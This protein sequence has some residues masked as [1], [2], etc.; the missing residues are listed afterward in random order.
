MSGIN[1]PW[2]VV[3]P[4][5]VSLGLL[6]S[7]QDFSLISDRYFPFKYL[8]KKKEKKY[9]FCSFHCLL[10]FLGCVPFVIIV[11]V[12]HKSLSLKSQQT[13]YPH[14]TDPRHSVAWAELDSKFHRCDSPRAAA[15]HQ[16]NSH[17]GA[18]AKLPFPFFT[19]IFNNTPQTPSSCNVITNNCTPREISP[20]KTHI[21]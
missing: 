18:Q 16:G 10:S 20:T 2:L 7:G 6:R 3:F 15:L 4:F 11:P 14:P 8:P 13:F 21:Y 19:L 1:Q 5:H 9:L 17:P 12:K